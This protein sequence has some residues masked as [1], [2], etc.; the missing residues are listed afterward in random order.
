MRRIPSVR[1]R[2]SPLGNT[3]TSFAVKSVSRA[4]EA[5]YNTSCTLPRASKSCFSGLVV[6]TRTSLR[7]STGRWS[8]GPQGKT[9][10][11]QHTAPPRVGPVRVARLAVPP[12]PPPR[13]FS[14]RAGRG[15]GG[16]GG[17]G[18]PRGRPRLF[19]A[20]MVRAHH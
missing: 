8:M 5:T 19:F 7:C 14:P 12:P 15:G 17:G 6:Y 4:L 3:S 16:G 10:G 20:P 9:L 1:L 18:P 11:L 2:A 13:A